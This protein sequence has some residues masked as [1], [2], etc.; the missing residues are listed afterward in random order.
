MKK[1]FEEC[2]C[3]CHTDDEMEHIGPCCKKC[4]K[5]ERNI[6][7]YA[8]DDHFKYCEGLKTIKQG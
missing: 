2:N 5:C 7:L 1:L 3:E 8:Y 4:P 6:K